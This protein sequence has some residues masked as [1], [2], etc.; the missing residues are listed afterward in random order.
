MCRQ[1][2]SST[3]SAAG[4]CT[5]SGAAGIR[6]KSRFC[7]FSIGSRSAFGPPKA[8]LHRVERPRPCAGACQVVAPCLCTSPELGTPATT[9]TVHHRPSRN[10]RSTGRTLDP[11]LPGPMVRRQGRRRV[12]IETE[13]GHEGRHRGCESQ[14]HGAHRLRTRVR[15][16]SKAATPP[17][18]PAQ[19]RDPQPRPAH[20][21]ATEPRCSCVATRER[22]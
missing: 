9:L 13:T 2:R 12:E 8:Q 6:D 21:R 15:H 18:V 14:Q 3:S 16:A 20:E 11:S 10:R 19:R 5:A 1:P 22:S 7:A 17:P 4:A